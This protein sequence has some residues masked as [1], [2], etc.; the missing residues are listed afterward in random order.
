MIVF[1]ASTLILLAKAAILREVLE[2]HKG[3]IIPPVVH[4]ECTVESEREDAQLIARLID[5]GLLKIVQPE[6]PGVIAKLVKDFQLGRGE[7]AALVLAL[8]K[9]A[10]LATDDLPARKACRILKVR[11]II[12]VAFLERLVQRDL[13]A[14][15]LALEKLK[16]FKRYGRYKAE[17]LEQVKANIKGKGG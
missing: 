4:R 3:S 17:T 6:R 8:E 11:A 12:A 14:P 15:E 16:K 13:L 1:D 10:L 7:A 9:K 2:H 5:E